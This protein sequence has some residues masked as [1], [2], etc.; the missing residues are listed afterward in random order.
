[1]K[2]C[3]RESVGLRVQFAFKMNEIRC[4]PAHKND[5]LIEHKN[6]TINYL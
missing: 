1:M 6:T 4:K 5:I 2:Y 3:T